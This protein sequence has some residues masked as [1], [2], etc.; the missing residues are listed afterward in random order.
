[1]SFMKKFLTVDAYIASAPKSVQPKLRQLRQAIM[2][3]APQAKEIMS[4]DMPYYSYCGRLAYFG[5][6]SDHLSLFAMPPIA[7]E[8]KKELSKRMSGKSTIR[9]SLDEKLPIGLIRR[10]VKLGVKRNELAHKNDRRVCS[11]GHVFFRTS[12]QPVCPVCWPGSRKDTKRL[13]V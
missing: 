3:I 5:Y 8:F 11:R 4:Y 7:N 2:S 12:A 10:L 1:M 13:H 9:F 6:F